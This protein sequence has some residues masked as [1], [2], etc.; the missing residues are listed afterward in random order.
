MFDKV[1]A[2]PNGVIEYYYKDKIVVEG[3]NM[4][5]LIKRKY[6]KDLHGPV[7]ITTDILNDISKPIIN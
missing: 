4:E 3:K 1:K 7:Q 2:Y 5:P 6:D